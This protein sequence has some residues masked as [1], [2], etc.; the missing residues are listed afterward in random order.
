MSVGEEDAAGNLSYPVVLRGDEHGRSGEAR[1]T[2][3]DHGQATG[4]GGVQGRAASLSAAR[5]ADSQRLPAG[6]VAL[7][8]IVVTGA[9]L[10]RR[11]RPRIGRGR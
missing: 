4:D 10:T 7:A 6:L 11:M 2:G 3:G 1:G 5:V 8:V 9:G